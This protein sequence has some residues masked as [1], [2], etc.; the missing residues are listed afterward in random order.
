MAV[1]VT[2]NDISDLIALCRDAV[3]S[4]AGAALQVPGVASGAEKLEQHQATL[5][6]LLE[7]VAAAKQRLADG[8]AGIGAAFAAVEL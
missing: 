3:G 2:P 4:A 5:V 7:R 8:D 1:Q 6:G